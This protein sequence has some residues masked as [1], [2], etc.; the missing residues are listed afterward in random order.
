MNEV[1]VRLQRLLPVGRQS[2]S[3]L[4]SLMSPGMHAPAGGDLTPTCS[5]RACLQ[6][7]RTHPSH[8]YSD[9]VGA[10]EPHPSGPL[11]AHRYPAAACAPAG[12]GPGRP[13]CG[14]WSARGSAGRARQRVADRRDPQQHLPGP[15]VGLSTC[16]SLG[17]V[18]EVMFHAT[19]RCYSPA[20]GRALLD[21]L[22]DNGGVFWR[23]WTDSGGLVRDQLHDHGRPRKVLECLTRKRS[24]VH[25]Q[26]RPP[27]MTR[28]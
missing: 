10:P 11:D 21:S 8:A 6:I 27:S 19:S 18:G 13:V 17:R 7:A 24:L 2:Y 4:R 28:P 22:L 9:H 23:M 20:W 25:I 12:K 15:G 5:S 26:Y 14:F 3:R 1:A 16:T